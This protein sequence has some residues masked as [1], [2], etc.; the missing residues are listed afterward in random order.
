[1]RAEWQRGL[2]WN[3]GSGFRAASNQRPALQLRSCQG[4]PARISEDHMVSRSSHCRPSLQAW[5]TPLLLTSSLPPHCWASLPSSVSPA[6]AFLFFPESQQ[7]PQ[8]KPN[9]SVSCRY[10]D[11]KCNNIKEAAIYRI[12]HIYFSSLPHA[13]LGAA[14]RGPCLVLI[15][16]T[17]SCAFLNRRTALPE[18][19][20][21]PSTSPPNRVLSPSHTETQQFLASCSQ[22]LFL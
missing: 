22:L 2:G 18:L 8:T 16:K 11:P 14:G 6:C 20:W 15:I 21:L 10:Q 12:V 17:H 19:C 4:P 1:M 7:P 9:S 5:R 13:S 3:L